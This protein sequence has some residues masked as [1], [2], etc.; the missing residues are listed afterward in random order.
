MK[1]KLD[2]KAEDTEPT[3][4]FKKELK[5]EIDFDDASKEWLKNKKKLGNGC[6]TYKTTRAYKY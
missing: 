4:F 6:Y 1:R 5:V 3:K 2:D